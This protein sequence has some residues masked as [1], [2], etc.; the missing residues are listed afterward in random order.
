MKISIN[1]L[2]V[3]AEDLK[4]S[5]AFYSDVFGYRLESSFVDTGTGS[6][7]AVLVSEQS[8]TLLIVPFSKERLP[9]PQHIA[10]EVDALS[11]RGIFANCERFKVATRSLPV[12]SAPTG[13]P[14]THEE[15]GRRYEH[16][17]FCDPSGV[18]L[19]VM[20]VIN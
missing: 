10:L 11:F 16:F 13:G 19:E 17:Y 18:N 8:P 15:L 5:V 4:D 12:L 7:G 1:H 3:G 9:S 14:V 2:I 6:E 20:R